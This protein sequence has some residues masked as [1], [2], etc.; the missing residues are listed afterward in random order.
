MQIIGFHSDA[1]T[2]DLDK[3]MYSLQIK[4]NSFCN[5]FMFRK[6]S[7]WISLLLIINCFNAFFDCGE[8]QYLFCSNKRKDFCLVQKP[9]NQNQ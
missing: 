7:S 3:D 2:L 6:I 4:I 5:E 9:R 1:W 8:L